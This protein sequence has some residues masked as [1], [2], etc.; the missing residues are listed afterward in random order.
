MGKDSYFKV[1]TIVYVFFG[2]GYRKNLRKSLRET[3]LY[4]VEYRIIGVSKTH[5]KDRGEKLT[6]ISEE[7]ICSKHHPY[8]GFG[9]KIKADD[10]HLFSYDDFNS[11]RIID[12]DEIESLCKEIGLNEKDFRK[13]LKPFRTK[14]A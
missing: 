7:R 11:L 12:D 4:F 9:L 10:K 8:G 6:L 1:G 2:G 14:D 5:E 13:G 3:D